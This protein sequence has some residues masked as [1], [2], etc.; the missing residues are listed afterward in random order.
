MKFLVDVCAGLQVA[1]F[2]RGRDIDVVEA[3]KRAKEVLKNEE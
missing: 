2:L 3:F 1:E